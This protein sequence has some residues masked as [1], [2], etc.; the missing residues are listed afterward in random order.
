MK[1]RVSRRATNAG[2]EGRKAIAVPGEP[3]ARTSRSAGEALRSVIEK[4][5]QCSVKSF[6]RLQRRRMANVIPL[7]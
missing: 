4:P 6:G 2:L 7:E 1:L 5:E 3:A